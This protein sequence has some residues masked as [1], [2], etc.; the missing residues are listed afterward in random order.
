MNNCKDELE[1]SSC[2]KPG[3]VIFHVFR[4][5]VFHL[6]L[7]VIYKKMNKKCGSSPNVRQQCYLQ[8]YYFQLF[9]HNEF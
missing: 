6:P 3:S 8:R 2:F 1:N 9:N 4:F 7:L 5:L